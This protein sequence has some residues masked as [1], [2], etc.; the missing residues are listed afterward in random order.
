MPRVMRI[1]S[2]LV[3][4]QVVGQPAGAR[5]HLGAAERLLVDDLVDRHLHQRRP[6]EVRGAALLDEDGVVAHPRGVRTAGGVR[7]ERHRDRRDAE[8]RQLGEVLE[9]RAALDEQVGLAWQVGTGRLVE[10]DH[11][12]PVLAG[13]LVEP[14]PLLPRRR[15]ARAAAVGH[16]RSADRALDAFDD[17][18]AGAAADAD[19]VLGAPPGERAELEERGVGIDERLDALTHQHLAA[20]AVPV[21]VA[22]SADRRDAR[23]L[24]GDAVPQLLHRREILLVLGRSGVEPTADHGADGHERHRSG[25]TSTGS[26][27]HVRDEHGLVHRVHLDPWTSPKC[28]PISAPN[29]RPS[30]TSSP[31][32]TPTSGSCRRRAPAGP[33]PTRSATSPT[34]TAT[35]RS[36]S[37][38][39]PRSRTPCTPCSARAVT[40][41]PP[42]TT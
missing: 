3:D 11:R 32:S 41:A 40:A 7:P 20:T 34:S 25:A 39:R 8:L 6:T 38:I 24:G 36:R 42:A 30:T 5:V 1:A 12:Q 15:V 19:G 9:A 10:H 35:P 33:S 22:L 21:D 29:S 17:A 18:D 23:H 37:P 28:S 4:G 27:A 26:E 16:V 13:D 31:A 14:R 2:S